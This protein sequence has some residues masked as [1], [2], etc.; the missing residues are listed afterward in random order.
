[1]SD[2]CL[3]RIRERQS[4]RRYSDEAIPDADIEEI[5]IA[6]FSVPS[7][8][9]RQTWRVVLVRRQD[10]K[11]RLS[12]AAGGQTFLAKAP[13]VFVICAVPEESAERYG[14][15]GRRLCAIQDAAALVLNLLLAAH[16][17]GYATCWIG[18]FN[19]VQV[20]RLLSIPKEIRPVAIVPVG[21]AMGNMPLNPFAEQ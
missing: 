13:I 11:E 5:L 3:K 19:E 8:G 14:E 16:V 1:M 20:V 10:F 15:R 6:G 9:N 21:K 12:A 2:N 17:L 4:I 7:A 18:A